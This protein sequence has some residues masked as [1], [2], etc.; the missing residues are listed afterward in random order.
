MKALVSYGKYDYR[1][2]ERPVPVP[3][4]GDI[5]VKVEACGICAG[6]LKAFEGARRFWGSEDSPAYVEPPAVPGHEFVGRIAETGSKVSEFKPGDR[7][8]AEQ[9]RPCGK[10]LYCRTNRYW[11]CDKHDVF[12]F[13]YYLNGGMA[14]YMLFPEGSLCHR[15]PERMPLEAAALIEPFACSKHG[16]DRAQITAEDTVVI[17]GSGTLGLGMVTIAALHKPARLISLDLDDRRLALARHFGA[18]FTFNPLKTDAVAQV[19]ALTDGYGCDVYIEATGHPDSVGQGLAMIRKGGRFV[20]FSVFKEP[21]TVDWSIIGDEKEITIY[22]SQLSPF[23]YPEVIRWLDEGKIRYEGVVTHKFPLSAWRE[24]F[25]A[26]VGREAVKTL[27][28]PDAV[29][30]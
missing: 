16:V 13:K 2:E 25:S 18:D 21:A 24:A 27:L 3:G 11:L 28:I 23:C 4:P 1:L 22:G 12:G 5:L 6:D 19:R 14:E 26:A 17:A 10:C 20:E 30:S 7:I 29:D 8:I 15:V 9:I